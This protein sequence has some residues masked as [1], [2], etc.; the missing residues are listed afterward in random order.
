MGKVGLRALRVIK[1]AVADSAPSGPNGQAAAVKE[2]SAPVSIFGRLVHN[3]EE[4]QSTSADLS[5][6]FGISVTWSK[7]GKM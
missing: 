4:L 3:L 7:A 6:S 1:G 5:P 2:I